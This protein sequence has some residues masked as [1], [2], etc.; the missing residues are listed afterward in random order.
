MSTRC[1][2][3]VI[4]VGT[5]NDVPVQLYHHTDGYPGSMVEIF[6]EAWT[7]AQKAI[8][9]RLHGDRKYLKTSLW[10]LG[11][12]GKV[13]GALCCADPLTME[14]ESDLLLHGDIE[15]LY[16]VYAVNQHGGSMAE[17]PTWEIEILVPKPD[18]HYA[19]ANQPWGLKSF[20]DEPTVDKM[21]VLMSRRPLVLALRWAKANYW[22]RPNAVVARE[23]RETE[24]EAKKR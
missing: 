7:L 15:Y 14:P 16:H 3:R 2:V 13:A 24:R 4:E 1:N 5:G 22:G 20:W 6:G 10:E 11:R 23:R 21:D 9:D 8:L 12:A 18:T 17:S 19:T